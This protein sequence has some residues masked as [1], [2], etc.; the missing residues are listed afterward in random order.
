[1]TRWEYA[2]LD[3]GSIST[4]MTDVEV[5]N[6]A[7]DEGWE[8]IAITGNNIAYFKRPIAA[9]R[10]PRAAARRPLSTPSSTAQ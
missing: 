8:L 3:L 2:R 6:G 1:M 10:K 7:G 5:L 9:Q 4:N